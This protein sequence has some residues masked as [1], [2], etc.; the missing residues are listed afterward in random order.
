MGSQAVLQLA[1][2]QLAMKAECNGVLRGEQSGSGQS[3]SRQSGSV[4]VGSLPPVHS[5]NR[6]NCAINVRIG[7][8][9]D[10]RICE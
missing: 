8:R 6:A 9:R 3:Y 10:V 1:V 7:N 4:A 5:L 2:G